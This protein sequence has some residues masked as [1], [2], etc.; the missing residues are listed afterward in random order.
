MKLYTVERDVEVSDRGTGR[1]PRF[2]FNYAKDALYTLDF[3]KGEI[4]KGADRTEIGKWLINKNVLK[5]VV[6]G[7]FSST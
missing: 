4:Y 1:E 2:S 5:E 3:K 6:D 7:D